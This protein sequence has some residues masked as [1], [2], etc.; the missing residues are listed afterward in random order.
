MHRTSSPVIS[1]PW[2]LTRFLNVLK[3]S[4]TIKPWLLAI[5]LT[6]FHIDRLIMTFNVKHSLQV[7]ALYFLFETA[8]LGVIVS[9]GS[10][11]FLSTPSI[12]PCEDQERPKN[13]FDHEKVSTLS[14][15]S[16][17]NPRTQRPEVTRQGKLREAGNYLDFVL[18]LFRWVHTFLFYIKTGL[19]SLKLGMVLDLQSMVNWNG[20]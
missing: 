15:F 10:T 12:L 1:K 17:L 20:V 7:A 6:I 9:S 14:H 11:L 16:R 13:I 8:S 19:L 5:R 4:K 3:Q 18:I 2:N